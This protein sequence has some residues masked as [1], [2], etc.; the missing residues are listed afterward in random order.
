MLMCGLLSLSP[1][2]D[3][4]RA[5]KKSMVSDRTGTGW[6]ADPCWSH[7][8]Y[9]ESGRR[10]RGKKCLDAKKEGALWW[11][12]EARVYRA[13]ALRV[14]GGWNPGAP[15]TASGAAKSASARDKSHEGNRAADDDGSMA[16]MTYLH[17]VLHPSRAKPQC[18]LS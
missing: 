3:L 14:N 15:F 2:I 18:L 16:R 6:C 13:S 8:R 11:P 17:C 12:R 10:Q 9:R 5:L 7:L 1:L 4:R